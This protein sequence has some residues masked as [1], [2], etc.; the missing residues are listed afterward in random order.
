[1]MENARSSLSIPAIEYDNIYIY[2]IV[3]ALSICYCNF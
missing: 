3:I 1:M 2:I